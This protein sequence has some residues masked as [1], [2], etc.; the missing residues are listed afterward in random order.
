MS[1]AILQMLPKPRGR[2]RAQPPAQP[3]LPAG[4]ALLNMYPRA[5]KG[6]S[7]VYAIA[8][9][10]DVVKVG[11][12]ANPRERLAN[13]WNR[14]RGEVLWVHLFESMHDDTAALAERRVLAAF[15][16]VAKPIE[17]SEWY[18]ADMPKREVL[19]LI[20]PVIAS[21]KEEVRARWAKEAERAQKRRDLLDA[22]VD[23]GLID[24]ARSLGA[25]V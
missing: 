15:S 2:K 22:M 3:E 18:F 6:R 11:R 10:G 5:Y 23:A 1:A 9:N 17:G 8:F 21:T 13:H 24:V 12:T 7:F 20:R 25:K 14:G 19:A 4:R 16:S